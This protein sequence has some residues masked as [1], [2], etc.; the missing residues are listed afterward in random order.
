M[1]TTGVMVLLQANRNERGNKH[2]NK[3][4]DPSDGLKSLGICRGP[5]LNP[6]TGL[7]TMPATA[8]SLHTGRSCK[9]VT[10]TGPCC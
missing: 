9:P 4:G 6:W 8:G 1:D 7:P 3:Q 2:W 10:G 5:P